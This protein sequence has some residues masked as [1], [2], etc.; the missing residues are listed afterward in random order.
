LYRCSIAQKLESIL[1][2]ALATVFSDQY[3]YHIVK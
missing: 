3:L 1:V 2:L